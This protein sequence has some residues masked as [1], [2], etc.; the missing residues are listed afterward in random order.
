[1]KLKESIEN[2]IIVILVGTILAT[3]GVVFGVTNVFHESTKNFIV[4]QHNLKLSSLVEEHKRKTI[5]KEN[6]LIQLK[7]EIA[8][9]DQLQEEKLRELERVILKENFLSIHSRAVTMAAVHGKN[10]FPSHYLVEYTDWNVVNTINEYEL[11]ISKIRESDLDVGR[12][13]SQRAGP[14]RVVFDDGTTWPIINL[15]WLTKP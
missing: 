1:M 13:V 9:L 11:A 2:N 3:A 10:V 14:S 5:K 4:A 12:V 7:S 15:Q 8:R 6:E